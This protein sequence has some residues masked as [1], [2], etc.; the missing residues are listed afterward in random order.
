MRGKWP[1]FNLAG[2][3]SLPGVG[4]SVREIRVHTGRCEHRVIYLAKF[5]E[6][7][8]ATLHDWPD[9]VQAFVRR[10]RTRAAATH[11]SA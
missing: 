2:S 10:A 8:P 7:D 11:R 3:A 5:D 9:Y 6:G 4:L 1:V